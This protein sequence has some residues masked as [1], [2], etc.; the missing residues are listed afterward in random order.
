[1]DGQFEDGWRSRTE[2][3]NQLLDNLVLQQS[4]MVNVFR[5]QRE[6]IRL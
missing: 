1:M 6:Q 2:Q 3:V 5:Y 4:L